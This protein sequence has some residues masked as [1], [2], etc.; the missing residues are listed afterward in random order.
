M[1][2][3][4]EGRTTQYGFVWG[5]IEVQRTCELPNG[6]GVIS[7]KSADAEVEVYFSAKGRTL[8][9]FRGGKELKEVEG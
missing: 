1:T 2:H 9:V 6:R 7:I 3:E 4:L 5:P 8:R